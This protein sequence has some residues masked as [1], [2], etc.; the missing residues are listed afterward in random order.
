MTVYAVD[1]SQTATWDPRA[2]KRAFDGP[3][4]VGRA[5]EETVAV[6]DV[7]TPVARTSFHVPTRTVNQAGIDDITGAVRLI[8]SKTYIQGFKLASES[9]HVGDVLVNTTGRH[10]SVLIT[11]EHRQL[12]FSPAFEA[13]RPT[14]IPP[15]A[16]WAYLNS[17]PGLGAIRSLRS[18]AQSRTAGAIAAEQLGELRLPAAHEPRTMSRVGRE[19][20]QP[21]IQLAAASEPASSWNYLNLSDAPTWERLL[22]AFDPVYRSE[23]DPLGELAEV[24]SG[25]TR[26][27]DAHDE[28]YDDALPLV[29]ISNLTR[30]YEPDRWI[31]P[32]T[33]SRLVEPGDI[34]VPKNG[35]TIIAR[36][37]D[38]VAV[39]ATGV[40][41]VRPHQRPQPT[42]PTPLRVIC[43]SLQQGWY[44]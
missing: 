7:A 19:L 38:R 12:A 20:P 14:G 6:G 3:A 39:P 34:L 17:K 16:L 21:A 26:Q 13:L 8:G 10:P 5:T 31:V 35:N 40:H 15:D 37:S 25:R 28:P 42:P 29:T 9:L 43:N 33:A 44:E 36:V 2:I 32:D 1:L 23:T 27:R 18:S 11:N 22:N 4:R 41:V 24:F 30:G